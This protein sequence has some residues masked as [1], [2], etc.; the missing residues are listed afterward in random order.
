[1]TNEDDWKTGKTKIFLKVPP[2]ILMFSL[3]VMD[4]YGGVQ[5]PEI[6]GFNWISN[7]NYGNCAVVEN[8]LKV[9]YL[10]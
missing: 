2:H 3:L 8:M 10:K 9:I 5:E 1:M 7:N 4:M 6:N